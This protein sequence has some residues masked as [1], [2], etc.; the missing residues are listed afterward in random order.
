MASSR[1]LVGE[2]DSGQ[3]EIEKSNSRPQSV[4]EIAISNLL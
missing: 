2:F 3:H 1:K 4:F